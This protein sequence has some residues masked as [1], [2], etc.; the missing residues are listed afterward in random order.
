MI[1]HVH[2][3]TF[4]DNSRIQCNAV[5][6]KPN[7]IFILEWRHLTVLRATLTTKSGAAAT[8]GNVR[9][10]PRFH[11]RWIW[12]EVSTNLGWRKSS[13]CNRQATVSTCQTRSVTPPHPCPHPNT[14]FIQASAVHNRHYDEGSSLGRHSSW[15]VVIFPKFMEPDR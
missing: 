5:A 8:L 15:V 2:N 1:T 10:C 12:S 14:K 3:T 7:S 13:S 11:W 6:R 4:S 9:I